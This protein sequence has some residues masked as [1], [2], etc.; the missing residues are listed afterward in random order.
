MVAKVVII[1][2]GIAGLA[3]AKTLYTTQNSNEFFELCVVEGG[4]RIGGRI[5]TSEFNG[6]QIEMGATWIHGIEGNPIYKIAQENNSFQSD[7]PSE[8]EE[9]ELSDEEITI[10]ED[11]HEVNSSLVESITTFFKKMIEFSE[12]EGD[13][14]D[15]IKKIIKCLIIG[16]EN[17]LKKVFAMLENMHRHYS[18]AGDLGTLDFNSASE[19]SNFPR[20]EI[21]I[22]KGF[23]T[24]IESLA[25][26][27]PDG[28]IQLGR[29]VTKIE[30]Q[31]DDCDLKLENGDDT[32]PVKLHLRDG[33]VMFADHVI[34]TVSLG[35]LKQGIRDD[36]AMFSPPLPSFKTQAISRL[37][38][39][40]VDKLFLQ[41]R[42]PSTQDDVGLTFPFLQT[43]RPEI[44]S[45][46][47]PLMD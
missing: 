19:Y 36:A 16:V 3:A 46:K 44:V 5:M 31:S 29:K 35:V 39:G 28:L 2:A 21:T 9:G 18:S 37:G 17:H 27:L 26:F 14:Q 30:W 43:I 47:S 12:G 38:F 45:P 25:S 24:V 20:D 8:C 1:G 11:G 7:K 10:T 42:S 32:Q 15:G 33:S 6:D 23:S 41:L 40:V 34:V 4:N 13:F 22:D